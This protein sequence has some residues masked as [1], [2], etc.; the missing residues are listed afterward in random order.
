MLTKQRLLNDAR[1]DYDNKKRDYKK[2]RA[3]ATMHFKAEA[4]CVKKGVSLNHAPQRKLKANRAVDNYTV[5]AEA[6][7]SSRSIYL[8]K[9]ETARLLRDI[10]KE[11]YTEL[12][13]MYGACSQASCEATVAQAHPG[14]AIDV[15]DVGIINVD[16]NDI[17][18]NIVGDQPSCCDGALHKPHSIPRNAEKLIYMF[19]P[20]DVRNHLAGD[21]EEEYVNVI[22]PKFGDEYAVAWYWK[23]AICIV[24]EHMIEQSFRLARGV[25][26][27]FIR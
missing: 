21:L 26:E 4:R 19:L 13:G 1:I 16:D 22:V 8:D 23:Q 15:I 18:A 20:H 6:V 25:I 9:I 7:H 10:A 3:E 14:C 12:F 24:S 27:I 5:Y 2:I 11:K 17:D